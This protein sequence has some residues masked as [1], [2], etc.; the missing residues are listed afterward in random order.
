MMIFSLD[1][2]GFWIG[3]ITIITMMVI[4]NIL[5]VIT[6]G[7]GKLIEITLI[8]RI[9]K[10]RAKE[11]SLYNWLGRP[12]I[13]IYRNLAAQKE[14][15][16]KDLIGNHTKITKIIREKYPTREELIKFKLVLEVKQESPRLQLI[17]HLIQTVL[18]AIITIP[19][20]QII[21]SFLN[22]T[23]INNW[24]FNFSVGLFVIVWTLMLLFIEFI[25]KETDRINF[26]LKLVENQLD[27]DNNFEK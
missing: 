8:K 27:N 15:N 23:E 10:R 26:L 1:T 6:F 16:D 9:E 20:T 17:K 4:I 12:N 13:N 25:S 14:V 22:I 7:L 21:T 19:L 18:L 5:M 3:V 2:G 11:Y 24:V